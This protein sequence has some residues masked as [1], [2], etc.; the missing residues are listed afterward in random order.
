VVPAGTQTLAKGPGQFVDGVAP[1]YLA[2]GCGAHV[3]DVDGNE[4]ID[5]S[6]G[7]GPLSLGYAYP[8][9]D[10]AILAQL[11]DGI[12]FSLMHPL[13]VEVAELVQ[14]VIPGAESVRFG[15]TGAEVTSAAVRLAR[16][17]TGRSKVLCCGYHGW[18]DWYISVTDRNRGIPEEVANLT[19]TFAYND[20]DSLL[21]SL[22]EEVA[23]V[24]LEPVTFTAPRPD[25]LLELRRAC[26]R[27]G[28]LLIFDEMW[29]GFRLALGGAQSRFDVRADLACF[30]KAIANGMPLSVLTGRREVMS[31]LDHDVF[32]FSTFG[33]EALSLA[34]ARATITVMQSQPVFDHLERQ[35]AR[36]RAGIDDALVSLGLEGV[37]C[38]G[39]DCR[40]L[41][42]FAPSLGDALVL[43][44]L[45][46]QELIKRGVLWGGIHNLSY[47]HTDADIDHAIAAY[48]EVLPILAEATSLGDAP[49]RL[50]GKP[51]APV[52]R[53]TTNFDTK[54]RAVAA[55]R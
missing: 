15:K 36:L 28:A 12:T 47:S 50:R 33:G 42:T 1:K 38:V 51:V 9:V 14:E 27:V 48:A 43:K 10:E 55:S 20:L 37:Q 23:A 45:V 19:F 46:Q 32:F 24:I 54:P 5:F 41:L 25:F 44:S 22:D 26:D 4:Y 13:E 34:A 2:R 30:S 7:V 8:A 49:A 40:T 31:L 53:R 16:A 35:G 29:T 3:W 52:F 21:S 39:Y 6:M 17:H 18:H 11:R